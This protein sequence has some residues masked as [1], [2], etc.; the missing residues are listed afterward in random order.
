M[1]VMLRRSLGPTA[2][3]PR[4]DYLKRRLTLYLTRPTW[5]SAATT[6]VTWECWRRNAINLT[7]L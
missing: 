7:N 5:I 3:S 1:I 4:P 6:P 2:D